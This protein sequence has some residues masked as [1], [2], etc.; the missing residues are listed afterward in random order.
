MTTSS[1][2][3]RYTHYFMAL[4]LMMLCACA[5]EKQLT[6]MPPAP[7]PVEKAPEEAPKKKSE[8]EIIWEK[9]LASAKKSMSPFRNQMT[10][11]YGKEGKTDR[12]AAL[13][14]G[15]SSKEI[16][17]DINAGVG[18]SVA[19]VYE[20]PKEFTLY[21]PR[22]KTAYLYSGKQK[23]L[24][25]IGVPMP[26]GLAQLTQLL[27]GQYALVFGEEYV[28][29]SELKDASI[30]ADIVKELPA[31]AKAYAL[32]GH[33]FEGTLVLNTQ[34]IPVYWQGDDGNGWIME[35]Q[36]RDGEKLPYKLNIQHVSS[37]RR[38]LLLVKERSTNLANFKRE[39]LRLTYPQ[40]TTV[41]PLEGLGQN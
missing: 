13:L 6:P 20:G 37:K 38:A 16:R 41:K 10:L 27:T 32:M 40:S 30:Q 5:K 22:E 11:R 23:P 21:L 14:W 19:K 17:L 8:A 12:A 39:Q 34:G 1:Y 33:D 24:F 3:P 4:L 31:K 18:V 35:L 25:S 29:I 9:Y 15:N 7:A 26:L 28:D 2:F 36:Y